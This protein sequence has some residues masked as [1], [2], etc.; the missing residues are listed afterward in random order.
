MKPFRL[1]VKRGFDI[2]LSFIGLVVFSP[3]ML[4]MFIL[5]KIT[6]PGP[7]FFIQERVGKGQKLFR[8]LKFRTMKIDRE[9][10]QKHDT[11]KDAQRVTRLGKFMRR[12]KIDEL[13]QLFNVLKGDMSLIGPRPTFKEQADQY[14]KRQKKR[15]SV[16]PGMT[17][18]AQVNGNAS[19]S[20]EERIEYDIQYV[21]QFTLQL[22]LII[23]LKTARVVLLGEEKYKRRRKTER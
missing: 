21:E 10:E 23:L 1:F 20:W 16:R 17:G 13:P 2:G 5:I 3:L 7:A 11:S 9:A 6:M 14:S 18:L 22:D 15:L 4:L 12:T 8:I 19:L